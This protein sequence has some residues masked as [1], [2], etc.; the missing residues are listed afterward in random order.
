LRLEILQTPESLAVAEAFEFVPSLHTLN[1]CAWGR[2][3][4][5]SPEPHPGP[6]LAQGQ[7]RCLTVW[8]VGASIL[9][10]NVTHLTSCKP[11]SPADLIWSGTP[12]ILPTTLPSLTHWTVEFEGPADLTAQKWAPPWIFPRF[13]TLALCVLDILFLHHPSELIDWMQGARFSLTTLMLRKCEMWVSELINLLEITPHLEVL[14]IVDGLSTIVTDRLL[15]YLTVR[16][17]LPDD[18]HLPK[19]LSLTLSGSFAFGNV[20]LVE[21]LESRTANG[22]CVCLHDVFLSLPQRVVQGEVLDRLRRLAM[23]GVKLFL[24]CFDHSNVMYRL[25]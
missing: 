21:M 7:I 5:S 19:L 4:S 22:D 12:A 18:H 8:G 6:K 24:E 15:R 2:I 20:V 1:I 17:E 9:Y 14:T 25:V 11:L 3:S 13:D 10:G 16:S 23:D